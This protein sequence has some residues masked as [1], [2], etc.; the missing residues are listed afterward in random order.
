MQ[1]ERESYFSGRTDCLEKHHVFGGSNRKWSEKYGLWVYLTHDE[2]NEPPQGVHHNKRIR[3]Q[4]QAE[5]QK[6]FEDAFPHLDFMKIFG[7]NYK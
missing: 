3:M 6:K 4:L 1:T 5:A 2:H 7:R